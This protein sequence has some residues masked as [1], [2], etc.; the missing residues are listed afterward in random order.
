M[1]HSFLDKCG[2]LNNFAHWTYL[3]ECKPDDKMKCPSR[4][5]LVLFKTAK[6]SF[7]ES[8]FFIFMSY[9]FEVIFFL[10]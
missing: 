10:F 5:A 4:S 3:D 2:K 9:Y 7:E 6:E 8:I 1:K